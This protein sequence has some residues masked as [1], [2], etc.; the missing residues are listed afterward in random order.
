ML[1]LYQFLADFPYKLVISLL[2]NEKAELLPVAQKKG[3]SMMYNLVVV[4]SMKEIKKQVCR[5]NRC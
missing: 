5:L 1:R 3:K 2:L 4:G